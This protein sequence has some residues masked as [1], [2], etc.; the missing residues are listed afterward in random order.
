VKACPAATPPPRPRSPPRADTCEEPGTE[1][2]GILVD[3]RHAASGDIHAGVRE[4]WVITGDEGVVTLTF[5][6]PAPNREELAALDRVLPA[7]MAKGPFREIIIDLSA[8]PQDIPPEVVRQVDLL[9]DQAMSQGI[10]A[11]I[12][13]PS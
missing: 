6:G 9:I 12:R 10:T 8:L 11:G 2:L 13:A 7:L 1:R 4:P 5:E 3:L